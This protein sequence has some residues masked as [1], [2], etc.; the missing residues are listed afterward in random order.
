MIRRIAY[1]SIPSP[2]LAMIGVPRII[3]CSRANNRSAGIG[4]VLVYTGADFL[5]VIEG[6]PPAVS[7]LWARIGRDPRHHTIGK[8]HD[9]VAAEAWYPE[10]KVGYLRDDAYI[11]LIPRWRAQCTARGEDVVKQLRALLNLS[12]PM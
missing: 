3:A 12:D 2:D 7:D 10:F 6:P 11:T 9:D 1:A 5:Q 4:G 8:F